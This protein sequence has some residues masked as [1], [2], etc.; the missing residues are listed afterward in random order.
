MVT[1]L[2]ETRPAARRG[3]DA[4]I[5]QPRDHSLADPCSLEGSFAS[6]SYSRFYSTNIDLSLM[7]RA[8]LNYKGLAAPFLTSGVSGKP[9]QML[10]APNAV[11][12][13]NLNLNFRGT[14]DYGL[15]LACT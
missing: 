12:S 1:R 7:D 6:P 2:R 3:Q 13:I 11:L 10:T 5:T 8:N 4:G 9:F 15:V 14:G